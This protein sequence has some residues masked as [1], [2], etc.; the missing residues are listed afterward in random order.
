MYSRAPES[1]AS[2]DADVAPALRYAAALNARRK[3]PPKRSSL[4]ISHIADASNAS[5]SDGDNAHN[6]TSDGDNYLDNDGDND[7]DV[8][9]DNDNDNDNGAMS[10]ARAAMPSSRIRAPSLTSA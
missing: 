5:S 2:D 3:T 8:E 9:N 4:S 7:G 6:A 1:D 10:E